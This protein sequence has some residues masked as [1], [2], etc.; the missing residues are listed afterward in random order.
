LYRRSGKFHPLARVASRQLFAALGTLAP[1]STASH[2]SLIASAA[3]IEQMGK[4]IA[5][6]LKGLAIQSSSIHDA[7]GEPLWMSSGVMGPDDYSLMLDALDCFALE[8]ARKVYERDLGDGLCKLV[9]PAR[10]PRGQQ[11]GAIMIEA[12]SRSVSGR[13]SEKVLHPPFAMLLRCLSMRLADVSC[14]PEFSPA[15]ELA[16]ASLTLYVQQ[17]L[18]LRSSGRTRRFEVLLRSRDAQV[19]SSEAP[20][21]ILAAADAEGSTGELDRHILGELCAWLASNREQLELEPANFSM[22]LSAGALRDASFLEYAAKLLRDARVNPRVLA[23]EIREKL[24]CR[25]SK[26]AERFVKTC[27]RMGFQVVIDDFTFH[28]DAIQLLRMRSVRV[29]KIDAS[30]TAAALKDKVAQAQV[31]AISQASKVLGMHCVAK[32]IDSA[33]ARQWLSAIGV[34]FAQGFLLEGP[35]P[36]TS[37]ASLKLREPERSAG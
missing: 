28:S 17:L 31:V 33:V 20:H 9:Y 15:G 13:A 19:D 22:N 16:A 21:A 37:L 4:E 34:D 27:E 2:P 36:L 5:V 6:A 24:C 3:S 35:L 7:A 23:F 32:R 10:D 14:G 30:L 25:Y 1:M 12:S 8:P 18:K 11:R 29:L 26:D